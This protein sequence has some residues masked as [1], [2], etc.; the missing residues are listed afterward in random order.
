MKKQHII[1]KEFIFPASI[2]LVLK[3]IGDQEI[4]CSNS[5]TVSLVINTIWQTGI[6]AALPVFLLILYACISLFD[7]DCNFL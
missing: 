1:V 3:I 5:K 7:N 2:N 6:I 4:I